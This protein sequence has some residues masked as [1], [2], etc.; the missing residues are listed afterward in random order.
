MNRDSSVL[1]PNGEKLK[2][3]LKKSVITESDMQKL[4]KKRGVF[5]VSKDRKNAVQFLTTTLIS[6]KEF[7]ELQEIQKTK[8]D[9][10]KVRNTALQSKTKNDLVEVIDTDLIDSE[11]LEKLEDTCTFQTDTALNVENENHLYIEYEVLREDVTLDWA[12]INRKFSGRID[13][14]KDVDTGDIRFSSEY[15]SGETEEINSE[16]IKKISTSLKEQDEIETSTILAQYS[17]DKLN[18]SYRMKFMLA[19]ANDIHEENLK[20][21]AVKNIEIGRDKAQQVAMQE[22]GLLFDDGVRNV[23]INGEKGET[24]N[25]IEYIV[26]E[27]YYNFLILRALQVEYKF[28]YGYA[29]GVCILEFG[30]PHFFRKSKKSKEFE[31][32]VNKVF[33][34]KGS[35]SENIKSV[36]RKILKDFNSFYQKEFNA[37]QEQQEHHD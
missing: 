10:V 33:L 31:V 8:E 35:R 24:L 25:N 11:E 15:T 5:N 21:N 19:L 34:N 22:A 32:I 1:L 36:T 12:H 18:N 26:N 14:I 2:P 17:S 6:P 23:I 9:N 20:F 30:F 16:I 28:D 4:L 13:I 27:A 3:L 29:K 7:E 37:M